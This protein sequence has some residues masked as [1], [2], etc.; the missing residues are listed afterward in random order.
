MNL[1][2]NTNEM[3]VYQE[4]LSII[5]R[6]PYKLTYDTYCNSW[7]AISKTNVSV[8]LLIPCSIHAKGTIDS[9]VY[10]KVWVRGICITIR[11]SS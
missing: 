5:V 7:G 10:A 9:R 6:K 4:A 8:A 1:V 2:T 3:T 11:R